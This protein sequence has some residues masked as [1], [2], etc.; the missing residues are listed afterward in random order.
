MYEGNSVIMQMRR[1]ISEECQLDES[2]YHGKIIKYDNHE[3]RIHIAVQ[4]EHVEELSLDAVY[5]CIMIAKEE[6]FSCDGM[7]KERY[8]NEN[9]DMVEFLVDNGFYKINIK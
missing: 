2:T 9:G 8:K 6:Q 3:E 1:P 7:M 4:T 5:E